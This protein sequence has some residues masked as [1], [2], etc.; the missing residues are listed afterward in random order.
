MVLGCLAAFDMFAASLFAGT[1]GFVVP[2][3]RDSAHSEFGYWEVFSAATG[4]PGNLPDQPGATTG[5]VLTQLNT[6]AILTSGGNIYNGTTGSFSL[7]DSVDF[8][9]GTVAL[10]ARTMGGELDYGSVSLV[11]SNDSG[12]QSIP[13]LF[14]YETDRTGGAGDAGVSSLWQWDLSGLGVTNYSV[15][16]NASGGGMDF[17]SLTLDVASQFAPAFA[18]QPFVLHS[19]PANLARWM[20]PRNGNPASRPAASI[21]GALGSSPVVDSRDAQFLLGWATTNHIPAGQGARNYLI[22]QA[23]VTL[24]IA[25]DNQYVYSGALRD[26]RTYF[27]ENDPRRIPATNVGS[28]VELFGAGYRGGYTAATFPQ[29]GPWGVIP[30]VNYAS[31]TVYAVGF[32]TNGAMVDVSNNVGDDG[33]NEI[34]GPFEVAPFAVGQSVDVA[35]GQLMPMGSQLAFDLNLEDPLIRGYV[36]NALDDGNLSLVA[37]SLLSSSRAGPPNYPTFHTSFSPIASAREYPLLDI[38]GGIMRR[39]VDSDGDGLPD[40]WENFHFGSLGRGADD[41]VD[42]D[43]ASNLA[44]YEAGTIPTC[45][46]SLFSILSLEHQTNAVELHFS[47]VPNRQHALHWSDDLNAWQIATNPALSYSSAWLAKTG[48]NIAY[49]APVYGIWRDTSPANHHRFYRIGA[50]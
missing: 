30:G 12:S 32:D 2:G 20:Y 35:E 13:P 7:T 29:D 22:R 47:V 24:T 1:N 18:Q 8:T 3:F 4:T 11:Y 50:E 48:T 40:D 5:A 45:E 36:Q 15:I 10:Q 34:I 17:D 33:T 27:P 43:G 31:R 19:V 16:F 37:S 41:D 28:T 46:T 44:E 21:F 25:S 49:P 39:S 42:G 26:Y 9:L 23:R 14:R 38:E 6:N